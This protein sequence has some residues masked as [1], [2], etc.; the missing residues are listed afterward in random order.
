LASVLVAG[1]ASNPIAQE[2]RLPNPF[3]TPFTDQQAVL[4]AIPV[5]TPVEK[6][7]AVLRAHGFEQWRSQRQGSKVTLVYHVADLTHLHTRTE[8]PLVILYVR[9]GEVVDIEMTPETSELAPATGR[10]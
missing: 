1:C 3:G 10:R 4:A 6:A 5:G 8:Y 2:V 9:A 7:E